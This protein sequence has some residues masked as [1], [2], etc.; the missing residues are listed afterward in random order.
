MPKT[1][2]ISG[3]NML[4]KS[5][6]KKIL[7]RKKFKTAICNLQRLQTQANWKD[8][9]KKTGKFTLICFDARRDSFFQAC[10]Q[11][12]WLGNVFFFKYFFLDF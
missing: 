7:Q 2:L 6:L 8:H 1:T 5:I 4:L 10:R 12:F 3:V 9:S 11:L